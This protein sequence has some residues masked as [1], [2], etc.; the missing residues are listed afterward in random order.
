MKK[1]FFYFFTF[2]SGLFIGLVLLLQVHSSYETRLFHR[3]SSRLVNASDS[4]QYEGD[5]EFLY[6]AFINAPKD[7]LNDLEKLLRLQEIT[8]I[9]LGPPRRTLF[10]PDDSDKGFLDKHLHSSMISIIGGYGCY[11]H[12]QVFG[13]LVESLG[14]NYRSF[15][16]TSN[17]LNHNVA[18]VNVNGKWLVFDA[19]FNQTFKDSLG[20]LQ[21][22]NEIRNNW[23][24]NK[25]Q[26]GNNCHFNGFDYCYN[27]NYNYQQSAKGHGFM[28]KRIALSIIAPLLGYEDYVDLR[29]AMNLNV[30]LKWQI[31]LSLAYIPLLLVFVVLKIYR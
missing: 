27:P 15:S 11:N 7:T 23:E 3:I 21:T 20:N 12:T 28:I 10:L 2:M 25:N 8:H 13:R 18:E 17:G 16:M 9:I 5:N 19:M 4:Q 31:L 29:T 1:C 14:Y 6:N 30:Y 26:V 22:S 24:Y